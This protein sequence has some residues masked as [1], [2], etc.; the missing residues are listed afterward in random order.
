MPIPQNYKSKQE[1]IKEDTRNKYER[2]RDEKRKQYLDKYYEDQQA[3]ENASKNLDAFLKF[4]SPS[5]YVGPIFRNNNKT[6]IDKVSSGEGTGNEFANI[7]L[8]LLTPGAILGLTKAARTVKAGYNM[9]KI[10]HQI[11]ENLNANE[12]ETQQISQL[13]TDIIRG[14][15]G[16]LSDKDIAN[17][18]YHTVA[19]EGDYNGIMF[20]RKPSK[21]ALEYA[22]LIRERF[23]G[24]LPNNINYNNLYSIIP[25]FT[26]DKNGNLIKSLNN[27]QGFY[28]YRPEL[29]F[30]KVDPSDPSI[31]PILTEIHENVAHRTQKSLS[32]GIENQYLEVSPV[33][34]WDEIRATSKEIDAFM[35]KKYGVDYYSKVDPYSPEFDYNIANDLWYNLAKTNGY[36]EEIVMEAQKSGNVQSVFEQFVRTLPL[37]TF[38]GVVYGKQNN[39]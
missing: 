15:Y 37:P 31:N 12:E 5:T 30:V 27:I 26:R 1:I 35:R 3:K 19:G 24:D 2:E 9:A 36:G 29:A 7:V 4:I 39:D 6:Y 10:Q 32:E 17:A 18:K 25:A 20:S 22:E 11:I 28:H 34:E 33:V 38:G 16:K 8:D 21:E 23:D 13:I 14:K